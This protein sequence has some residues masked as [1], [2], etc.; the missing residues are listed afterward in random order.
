MAH[1]IS[2]ATDT[3]KLKVT[4]MTCGN[5]ARSVERT[6]AAIPGVGKVTVDLAGGAATAEYDGAAVT[7]DALASAVR[8]LGYG[9]TQ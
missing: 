3:L 6:L 7:P 9:A 5:C 2:M 4:G 1:H 8:E